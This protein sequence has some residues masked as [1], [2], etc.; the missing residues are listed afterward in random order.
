MSEAKNLKIKEV[1]VISLDGINVQS[2]LLSQI[3]EIQ[4]ELK[5]LKDGVELIKKDLD[6]LKAKVQ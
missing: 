1:G 3:A 5:S 2:M 6:K 4:I